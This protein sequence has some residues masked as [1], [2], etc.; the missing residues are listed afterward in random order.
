MRRALFDIF[1]NLKSLPLFTAQNLLKSSS[2][3]EIVSYFS[4]SYR[5]LRRK[6][7]YG[8]GEKFKHYNIDLDDSLTSE[9]SYL[10]QKW[11]TAPSIENNGWIAITPSQVLT[12][13]IRDVY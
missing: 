12:V 11:A 13:G 2:V 7:K 3:I 4:L 6:K 5:P 1:T 8:G 9:S 10:Y